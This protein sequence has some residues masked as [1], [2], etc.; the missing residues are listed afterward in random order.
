MED[1][2]E[3]ITLLEVGVHSRAQDVPEGIV[4]AQLGPTVQGQLL[5]TNLHGPLWNTAILSG[6]VGEG[7]VKV[8]VLHKAL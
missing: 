8:Q 7:S 3:E 2:S 4:L 6:R 5:D 1:V